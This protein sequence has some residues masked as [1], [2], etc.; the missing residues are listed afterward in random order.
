MPLRGRIFSVSS[1]FKGKIFVKTLAMRWEDIHLERQEWLIPDT[2]NDESLRVPLVA[3]VVE[4]L[5]IRLQK[6]GRAEWVFEGT[7]KTVHLVEPKAG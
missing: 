6:Y 2:K 4:I 3:K 5:K 7:G 1:F